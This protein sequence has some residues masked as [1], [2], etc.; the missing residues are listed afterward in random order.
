M[1]WSIL[2][3]PE[4]I[5]K[6]RQITDWYSIW[7][8]T[9]WLSTVSRVGGTY[10]EQ[11]IKQNTTLYELYS[12]CISMGCGK[13][14]ILKMHKP[15]AKENGSFLVGR[16]FTLCGTS[17]LVPA[18]FICLSYSHTTNHSHSATV[19]DRQQITKCMFSSQIIHFTELT[20]NY[21]NYETKLHWLQEK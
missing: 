9:L 15:S 7:Q 13:S 6:D 18:A 5:Q 21:K 12:Y 16:L 19:R 17:C 14:C 1:E 11:E 10:K 8:S 20:S 2:S 4:P 3:N